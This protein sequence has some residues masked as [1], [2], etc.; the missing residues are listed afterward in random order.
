LENLFALLS[1]SGVWFPPDV[2]LS[3]TDLLL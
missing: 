1:S 3:A 2:A